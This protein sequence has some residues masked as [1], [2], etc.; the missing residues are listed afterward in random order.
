MYIF[1]KTKLKEGKTDNYWVGHS[2]MKL[3]IDKNRKFYSEILEE[4]AL[5]KALNSKK[6][7]PD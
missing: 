1:R 2:V 6:N 7:T 4:D 5:E 3:A